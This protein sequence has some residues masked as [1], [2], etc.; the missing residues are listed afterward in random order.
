V[1]DQLV[2]VEDERLEHGDIGND[3]GAEVTTYG[4][5]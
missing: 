2:L 4:N 1:S 5:P 3:R